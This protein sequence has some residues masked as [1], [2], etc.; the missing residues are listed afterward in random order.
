MQY[1]LNNSNQKSLLKE[2]LLI[3]GKIGEIIENAELV[4]Q[5]KSED[6]LHNE[7]S[8]HYF[9]DNPN[10]NGNKYKLVFD[11]TSRND[12]ENHYR[13]Q[14]LELKSKKGT[15]V[16]TDNNISTSNLEVPSNN[17]I[18]SEKNYV[19][20]TKKTMNPTEIANLKHYTIN[21]INREV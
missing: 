16:E 13:V 21:K 18:P 11:V 17:I 8:W 4:S 2:H 7:N 9:Y 15:S 3:F 10:I 20:N 5:N 6:S 19:N 12:G 1:V 14:T